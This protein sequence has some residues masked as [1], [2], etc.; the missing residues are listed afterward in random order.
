[1][2]Q[3]THLEVGAVPYAVWVDNPQANLPTVHVIIV[4]LRYCQKRHVQ[5]QQVYP[6]RVSYINV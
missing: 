2:R 5:N 1:M 6:A 4:D 3:E